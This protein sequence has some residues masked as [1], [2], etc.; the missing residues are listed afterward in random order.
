M[1]KQS[2]QWSMDHLV[3][4][5]SPKVQTWWHACKRSN[6]IQETSVFLLLQ[7]P[8]ADSPRHQLIHIHVM[9]VFS[10]SFRS[11]IFLV[12]LRSKSHNMVNMLM[13][14][15]CWH[16][17][18]HTCS[19]MENWV[20][21]WKVSPPNSILNIAKKELNKINLQYQLPASE[22]NLKRNRFSLLLHTVLLLFACNCICGEAH[23][24]WSDHCQI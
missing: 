1:G 22:P 12:F 7:L 3:G 15:W 14:A 9:L 21:K 11:I 24:C 16:L 10:I 20:H 18:S 23:Y 13:A 17:V 4:T 2:I 8:L 19:R 5:K 6:V